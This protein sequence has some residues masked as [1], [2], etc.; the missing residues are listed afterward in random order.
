[1]SSNSDDNSAAGGCGCLVIIVIAGIYIYN[2]FVTYVVPYLPYLQLGCYGLAAAGC[3]LGTIVTTVNFIRA[4]FII[5]KRRQQP[6]YVS[7]PTNSLENYFY[8]RGAWKKDY[9]GIVSTFCSL[10]T[11]SASKS[12]RA[13]F[14]I[15]KAFW[16]LLPLSIF[17]FMCSICIWLGA[18]IFIPIFTILLTAVMLLLLFYTNLVAF[19]LS[20]FE[21]IYLRLRRMS[22]LCPVCHRPPQGKLP[23][24]ICPK[25]GYMHVNL[26]PSAR[27]GA[28]YQICVCKTHLPTSRFFGRNKLPAQC[29]H[30][31]CRATFDKNIQ[32]TALHTIAFVG[33]PS[34]GKTCLLNALIT[35]LTTR[36]LPSLSYKISAPTQEDESWLKRARE[37]L[38]PGH[39]PASTR[40][41]ERALCLDAKQLLGT[42]QRLYF[43]D[44]PGE[45]FNNANH[46]S[47]RL[48]Y[49]YLKTALFIIDPFSLPEL[50]S[51]LKP[52]GFTPSATRSGLVTPEENL[53]QWLISIERDFKNKLK[54]LSCAVVI[55][56]ADI[57]LLKEICGLA[58]GASSAD[59]ERFLIDH[60]MGHM[61]QVLQDAFHTNNFFAVAARPEE[62]P[63]KQAISPQGIDKV[64]DWLL[65]QLHIG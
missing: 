64:S 21:S 15:I 16:L 34:S 50:Q 29:S 39:V 57:P 60:G 11:E 4:I 9:V 52:H 55:G 28:F 19:E 10:N 23:T 24:Y 40:D 30:S 6:R 1:M 33:A 35:D 37:E 49:N 65:T 38:T 46:I 56:K 44:P 43:Y 48:Y 8:W 5:R 13:G 18:F 22:L 20:I 59:C 63:S 42:T 32:N 26:V 12:W 27:Y 61:L 17:P 58:P 3:L 47:Q 54:K 7:S 62:S 25:C 53:D 41:I 45:D 2:L 36:A 51:R 31:D 14:R